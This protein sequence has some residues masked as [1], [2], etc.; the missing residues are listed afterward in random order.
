MLRSALQNT[1]PVI[2]MHQYAI[3]VSAVKAFYTVQDFG[4]AAAYLK[5]EVARDAMIRFI[6]YEFRETMEL[7]PDEMLELMCYMHCFTKSVLMVMIQSDDDD[8][9]EEEDDDD[10]DED[11][12][13]GELGG[14]VEFDKEELL[15]ED[16]SPIRTTEEVRTQKLKDIATATENVGKQV[17]AQKIWSILSEG[18]KHQLASVLET[19]RSEALAKI[20]H[21]EDVSAL[22]SAVNVLVLEQALLG[23]GSDLRIQ[24][25]K[26]QPLNL[27][28]VELMFEAATSLSEG[29]MREFLAGGAELLDQFTDGL[30]SHYEVGDEW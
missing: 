26:V 4:I 30:L 15:K 10:E 14:D 25:E 13:D 7:Y 9:D 19:K 3:G 6:K 20:V 2:A 24:A 16:G 29:E 18:E 28:L 27:K 23:W 1:S 21:P 5:G 12:D 17:V 8:E 11:G 22:D